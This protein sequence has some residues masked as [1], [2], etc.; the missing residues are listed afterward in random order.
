MYV[1]LH[2]SATFN[3]SAIYW[4]IA[5]KVTLFQDFNN[6]EDPLSKNKFNEHSAE[7]VKLHPTS[8]ITGKILSHTM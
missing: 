4:R 3:N 5:E 8:S 7:I 6:H 1:D 2:A